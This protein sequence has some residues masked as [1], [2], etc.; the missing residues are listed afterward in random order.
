MPISLLL[1]LIPIF[2]G[3][4][5]AGGIGAALGTITLTE[6]AT[7]GVQA[8]GAAPEALK[9]LK[10]LHPALDTFVTTLDEH[11]DPNVAASVVNTWFANQPPTISGYGPDGGVT[12]IPNPDYRG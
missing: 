12:S 4:T 8:L 9:L 11:K 7:I 6:W 10:L 1:S 3:L 2:T 5:G